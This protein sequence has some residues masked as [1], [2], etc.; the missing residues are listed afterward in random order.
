[1][2]S[3]TCAGVILAGETHILSTAGNLEAQT[4]EILFF[5]AWLRD[6][7]DAMGT[8]Y[9]DMNVDGGVDDQRTY[10]HVVPVAAIDEDAAFGNCPTSSRLAINVIGSKIRVRFPA[11]TNGTFRYDLMGSADLRVWQCLDATEAVPTADEIPD[12]TLPDGF[13]WRVVEVQGS[14]TD[15]TQPLFMRVRVSQ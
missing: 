12:L 15:L 7:K 4:Y 10:Q 3:M 1:M 6:N 13:E 9:G 8:L 5:N 14:V 11:S 2:I